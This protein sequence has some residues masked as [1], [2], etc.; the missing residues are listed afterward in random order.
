MIGDHYMDKWQPQ[1][2]Y[3]S[4][5]YIPTYPNPIQP[6]IILNPPPVI[7][8]E[9][10]DSLKRDVAEMKELLKRAKEYD[11]RNGEPDCEMD[12]KMDVLRRVAKMVGVDL[13]DVI[14]SQS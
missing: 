9:E 13:D 3:P 4:L 11:E 12:E 2:W 10:F 14:G 7:S 1:P 8:K 6:N 5:P